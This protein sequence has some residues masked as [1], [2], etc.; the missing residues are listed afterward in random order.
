M[1]EILGHLK[2]EKYYLHTYATFEEL[3]RDIGDYIYF[4]ITWDISKL[5]GLR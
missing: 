2:S 4:T 5:N 1:E 3:K